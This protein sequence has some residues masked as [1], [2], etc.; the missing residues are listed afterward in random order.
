VCPSTCHGNSESGWQA[1]SHHALFLCNAS[2]DSEIVCSIQVQKVLRHVAQILEFGEHLDVYHIIEFGI[3]LENSDCRLRALP[4]ALPRT[5]VSSCCHPQ[6]QRSLEIP[7]HPLGL[8]PLVYK[9]IEVQWDDLLV[10][11]KFKSFLLDLK[12]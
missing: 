5:R 4:D 7:L 8:Y 2:F 1:L 10:L 12:D 6:S 3:I 9:S 11:P